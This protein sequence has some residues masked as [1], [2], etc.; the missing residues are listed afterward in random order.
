MFLIEYFWYFV[1]HRG[2]HKPVCVDE[3][4]RKT[5]L[6]RSVGWVDGGHHGGDAQ[7]Y[8]LRDLHGFREGAGHPPLLVGINTLPRTLGSAIHDTGQVA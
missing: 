8:R 2:Q 6:W 5:N 4:N 1:A 3:N 7:V